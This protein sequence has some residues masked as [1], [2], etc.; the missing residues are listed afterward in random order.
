[1]GGC[2]SL[3]SSLGDATSI[4]MRMEFLRSTTMHMDVLHGQTVPGVLKELM[5]FAGNVSDLLFAKSVDQIHIGSRTI[6]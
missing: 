4:G 3:L 2:S 5:G 6:Q 1:M